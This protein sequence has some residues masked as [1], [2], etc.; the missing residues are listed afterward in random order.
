MNEFGHG[1]AATRRLLERLPDEHLAG[2]PHGKSMPP[3]RF[4]GYVAELPLWLMRTLEADELVDRRRPA[5]CG[6]PA[7]F[8]LLLFLSLFLTGPGLW[9][10]GAPLARRRFAII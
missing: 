1:A 2:R 6:G 7:F 4:A 5:A 9:S 8:W 3:G 10:R